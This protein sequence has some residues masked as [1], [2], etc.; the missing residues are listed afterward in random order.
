MSFS[1]RKA[2]LNFYFYLSL[3]PLISAPL[4]AA[5]LTLEPQ[6]GF[7]G[8][9][10]LGHPFPLRV[11]LTNLGRPV[12]GTLEV[13]VW[14]GGPSKGVAAYP[15]Y[16]RREV[17]LSAQ[18]RKSVQFTVDPDSI[19]R[20]LTVS[21]SSPRAKLSKEI[22]L[23]HHFSPSPLILLLTE[24]S[25][26]PPIPLVSGSPSPLISLSL[27]HLPSDA[28][29]IQGVSTIIFYEQ[30]LRDLSRRQMIALERWLSSGGRMLVLGSIH[31]ALYQE[32]SM[33][34]FLPVRVVGLKK[35]SSLPSLER[36]Y[37]ESVSSLRNL[38]VQDSKLVEGTILIEEK[39]T[40]I[41][42]EMSRGLGKV[43][44]LALDVGRPPLSR[45]EGLSLL[46]RDLLGPPAERGSSFQTSWDDAV[47]SQLLVSHSLVSVRGPTL[48]FFLWLLFYLGGLGLLAR[49]W[50]Q[51]RLP[52]RTLVLSF[53]SLVVFSSFG[54][55]LYFDRGGDIPDGVLL[56]STLLESLPDG[57]VEAQSGVAIFSTR[58]RQYD[59][60]VENGWTD[61]ELVRPRFEVS[62]DTAV[63][64]QEG[65]G[66]T[67]FRFPLR[68]WSYRLFKVRSMSRFPFRTEIQYQGDRLFLRLTNLTTKDLTECWVV[69]SGQSFF[70]GDILQG[71]SQLREFP[72]S[73]ERPFSTDGR[74]D[75]SN[76]AALR[77]IPF[78]DKRR[79]VLFHSSFF[80]EDQGM[81]RWVNGTVLLF[82]WVKEAAHRVWVD[83]ARILA[84][85]YTLF[86]TIIPLH[87]EE[88]L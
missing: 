75:N 47:F 3:L 73:S 7:H 41:L 42:V 43:F 82:G 40:P 67:R 35:F 16:Y 30:S 6:V 20:P 39:G 10:Q 11:S 68:E 53:L 14:K 71:S 44:Y 62:D 19:S 37:G 36:S 66:S 51:R 27:G 80:P 77:E 55:Y 1:I 31:Y 17:F 9:F 60:R 15:F 48:S 58:R 26:P 33:S 70:L 88:E 49:L 76:E 59:L 32:P 50:Q 12:E 28:R 38:W 83:D 52:Q 87:E 69:I 18:S 74:S 57:Y 5:E 61:F 8:L 13:K 64:V 34:R 86:R 78:D 79:E 63:V 21:F 24:N 65:G 29:A 25:V 2:A 22:D 46:F 23:R 56:S 85:D 84:Y 81:G 54:G 45:W 4:N 72:L